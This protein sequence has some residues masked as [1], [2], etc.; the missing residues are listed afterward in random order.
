MVT[1]A[2]GRSFSASWRPQAPQQRASRK[3]LPC[4]SQPR[5]HLCT[6]A[7]AVWFTRRR[8]TAC[9]VPRWRAVE[10]RTARSARRH[11]A[12]LR[13]H[14]TKTQE[15]RPSCR[16][17]PRAP[18]NRYSCSLPPPNSFQPSQWLAPSRRPGE[19]P[20]RAQ[21]A[22]RRKASARLLT[23]LSP[24]APRSKSTGGKAPR[25]QLATK[26]AR[27]SAPATGGVKKVRSGPRGGKRAFVI[28]QLTPRP[29]PR[30]PTATARAPWRCARSASTRRARSC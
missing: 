23:R 5:R 17:P 11:G 14:A 25:K 12:A 21:R 3:T 7:P 10:Q 19:R 16:A 27:K 24:R 1:S 29:P 26:A 20:R 18:R 30:S 9:G 8:A 22:A 2:R 13:N 15:G 28:Q 6:A 4:L